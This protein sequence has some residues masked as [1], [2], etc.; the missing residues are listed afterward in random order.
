MMENDD[1]IGKNIES[2]RRDRELLLDQIRSSQATIAR[3]QQLLE[4]ID[5]LLARVEPNKT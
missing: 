4:K 5:E 1:I 3:S 2:L